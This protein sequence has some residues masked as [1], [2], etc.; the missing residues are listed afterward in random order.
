MPSSPQTV[1]IRRIKQHVAQVGTASVWKIEQAWPRSSYLSHFHPP[2][3]PTSTA[4]PPA[5]NQSQ[6]NPPA[7]GPRPASSTPI[8]ISKPAASFACTS[9]GN[10]VHSG[11]RCGGAH[12]GDTIYTICLTRKSTPPPL[13]QISK[14][15]FLTARRLRTNTERRIYFYVYCYGGP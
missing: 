5:S 6:P 2:P 9:G 14:L 11:D 10:C 3:P 13:R 7:N 15:V 4:V 1:S 8:T 12:G